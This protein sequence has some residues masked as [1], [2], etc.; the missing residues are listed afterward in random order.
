MTSY[1]Q[2]VKEQELKIAE[3]EMKI[4]DLVNLDSM[5]NAVTDE[6]GKQVLA[7]FA[8]HAENRAQLTLMIRVL[9]RL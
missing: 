8:K 3:L 9:S 5:T 6:D 2:I 1:K 7:T 4:E